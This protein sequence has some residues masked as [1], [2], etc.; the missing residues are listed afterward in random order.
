MTAKGLSPPSTSKLPYARWSRVAQVAAIGLALIFVAGLGARFLL[1]PVQGNVLVLLSARSPDQ[2]P[3]ADVELHS[4]SGSWITVGRVAAASVPAAPNTVT[5]ADGEA[6][7]GDYDRVRFAGQTLPA[8][9]EVRSHV[10]VTVLIAI[11]DGRPVTDGV[12][13]GSE[14]VSLGLNELSGQLKPMP[15]FSLVDQFGRS[16]TNASISG[17]DVILAAFH[18]TCRETCPLITGLFMQLRQQ[19]PPAVLLVEATTDPWEDTPDRLRAYAGMIGA[20]WI[21]ATGDP[22]ALTAFWKSFDVELSTADVHRSEVALIDLHGYI[23]T[24]FLGAPDVGGSLPVPLESQLSPQGLAL[25]H[26]HG[27]GWGEAQILDALQSVGGL[28]SPSSSG[29]GT[30][31]DFTLFTLDGRRV[32]LR[33]FKGQP[34]LINFWATYCVPCRIEMPLIEKV[35]SQH[36]RLVVLLV[37]E[38]DDRDAARRFAADLHVTSTVLYDGDGKV[39]DLYGITGLPTTFFVRADGT[40]EGRYIGQT[41]DSILSTHVAAIGA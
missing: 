6:P 11:S 5:A 35:A 14:G 3:A 9:V 19:L 18:S 12:Y 24:Y 26:S 2:V 25:L 40:I 29:G 20:S 39:G 36:P 38:R 27:N 37:D 22:G 15:P 16:F 21:F 34:V 4:T 32:S 23:R 1:T 8:R 33:D 17:H 30:A 41:N 28:A 7:V 13:A 31:D 10:L